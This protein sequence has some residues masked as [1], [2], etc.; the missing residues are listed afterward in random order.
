MANDKYTIAQWEKAKEYFEAGL[1]LSVITEKTGIS[2]SQL[3]KK[4]N[5]ESWSKETEKKQLIVDAARL[6]LAKE[7]LNETALQ[8]HEE[9]VDERVHHIKFFNNAAIRN[10][11]E[12]MSMP[13]ESQQD[14]KFRAETINKGRET[15]LGKTPDT[16]IQINNRNDD[17][18][19]K[20]VF[21]D[22]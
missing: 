18:G 7:T 6:E 9:L 13:C 20:V 15:V 4:A 5:A 16:A 2:K 1:S 22:D 11:K 12:S 14:F 19:I 8:V 21:G 17:L 3:S 10:V